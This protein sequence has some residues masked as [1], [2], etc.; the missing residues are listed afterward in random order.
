MPTEMRIRPHANRPSRRSE[1]NSHR[2]KLAP[3]TPG[4]VGVQTDTLNYPRLSCLDLLA[5]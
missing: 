1:R 2:P 3:I 5:A 4:P